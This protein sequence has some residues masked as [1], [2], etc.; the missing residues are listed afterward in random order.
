MNVLFL[1]ASGLMVA[2]ALAL[3]LW[4]LLRQALKQTRRRGLIALVVLFALGLPLASAGLYEMLGN[5]AALNPAAAEQPLTLDQAI[6]KIR[7]QLDHDSA[8]PDL[9]TLLGQAYGAKNEPAL[10]ANAFEHALKYRPDDA[11]LLV[12]WA[13]A[14]SLTQPQHMIIGEARARLERALAVDPTHQRGLWLL[15]I[16]D[17]QLQRYSEAI[18]TWTRLLKLLPVD[19]DV[20]RGVAKQVE[21]AA[22]RGALKLSAAQAQVL[23]AA[24][25]GA[26]APASAA[27]SAPR[28]TVQV[29]LAPQLASQLASH[30]VLFVYAR[31]PGGPPMP[32]A[33]ARLPAN[34]LPVTVTLTDAMSM[35]PGMNL[36]SARQVI[37]GARLSAQGQA[38]PQP[39]DLQGSAGPVAVDR[40]QPIHIVI[41]KVVQQ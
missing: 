19:S 26:P 24:T 20:A 13:Q 30:P 38:L 15:G 1:T 34:A 37:V 16:S 2:L 39:G 9:W 4:P 41:D 35:A 31:N 33:V 21:L 36:S 27:S 11:D 23:S 3:V 29:S 22:T 28:L 18:A 14:D 7:A 32:L 40:T 6:T 5:P 10:A 12:A 8:D 17:F 25:A